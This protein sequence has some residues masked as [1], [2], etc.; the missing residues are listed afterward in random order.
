MD[1]TVLNPKKYGAL[2]AEAIPKV[3]ENDE[4]FSR[5]VAKLEELTFKKNVTREEAELAKLLEKLVMVY[6]DEHCEIP[7]VPP[8]QMVK[9][10]MDQRGLKQADLARR[11][12]RS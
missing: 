2:C 7:D 4:E 6:E 10:F 11:F 5:M 12:P 8:H 3:I 9:F 1:V